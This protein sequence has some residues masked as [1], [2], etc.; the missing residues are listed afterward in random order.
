[1]AKK[2]LHWSFEVLQSVGILLGVDF[3]SLFSS[4]SEKKLLVRR[5]FTRKCGNRFKFIAKFK[6]PTWEGGLYN[7]REMNSETKFDIGAKIKM[8]REL[9]GFSQE[10]VAVGL[11]ISQ[12]AF[13][14]IESGK[15]KIDLTRASKIANCLEINLDSLMSFQPKKYIDSRT[16]SGIFETSNFW[17]EKLLSQIREQ[18]D[19]LKGQVEFLREQNNKLLDILKGKNS[20][21]N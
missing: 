21:K 5:S 13:Q 17:T 10:A 3:A 12:Q 7:N 16:K 6:G 1:L 4:V 19:M 18:N 14:Q 2:F 9:K 20:S 11:G 15:T 8:I